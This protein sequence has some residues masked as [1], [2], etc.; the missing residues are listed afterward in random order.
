MYFDTMPREVLPTIIKHLFEGIEMEDTLTSEL[1]ALPKRRMRIHT[2][3]MLVS[4]NSPFREVP[5]QLVHTKLLLGLISDASCLWTDRSTFV[6]GPELFEGESLELGLPERIFQLIGASTRT[7]SFFID[8]N[9]LPPR[10]TND[11]MVIHEFITLVEMYCPNVEGLELLSSMPEELSHQFEA[12]IVQLLEKF[13]LQLRSIHWVAHSLDDDHLFVPDI[14]LCT[15]IRELTFP[16]SPQLISFFDTSGSSL[17]NLSISFEAIDKYVDGYIDGYIDGYAK[18]FDLILDNCPKLS[19][20]S[21]FDYRRI[22]ETVGE[23]QYANF[24]CS[25]GSQLIRTLID[26]LSIGKL[27]QVMRACP[28]LL[29]DNQYVENN[30]VDGWERVSFLGPMIKHLTVAGDMCRDEKCEEAIAKCTNLESLTVRRNYEHEDGSINDCS[31]LVFLSSISSS[32]LHHF[33]HNDFLATQPNIDV[34]SLALRNLHTLTLHLSKPMKNGI[35]FT[36]IARSN[37]QLNSVLIEESIWD[38]EE[39]EKDMSIE[40]LRM[41]V[42]A[43]S[44]CR[45]IN[46]TLFKCGEESVTREEIQDICGSLPCRGVYVR[47][48]VGSTRYQQSDRFRR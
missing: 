20:V 12:G 45:S 10:K 28:N 2:L 46:F 16:F 17:E 6:I 3:S 14:S 38:D 39:R 19:R 11:N 42:N 26:E 4:E 13:S 5:S 22:I 8:W 23:E 47:I 29:I 31:D 30:G 40:L 27:A 48:K 21:L 24:L 7:V 35:D 43:F 25:F 9:N 18:M 34:L 32:S 41:L 37:P 15:H 1:D 36:S 33:C 44:K